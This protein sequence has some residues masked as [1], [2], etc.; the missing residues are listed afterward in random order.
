[1]N[2][3]N[4]IPIE[5]ISGDSMQLYKG[6][7]IGTGKITPSE[8]KG[9]PHYMLDIKEA[10]ESFSVAEF[11]KMV[12]YYISHIHSKQKI[13][14]IVGGTGLYIQ[15][16]LYDYQFQDRKRDEGLTKKLEDR[17]Q[18]EGNKALYEELLSIDRNY[19]L[20]I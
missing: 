6:M 14:V 12:Q 9:I 17:I 3:A 8:K 15:A 5:I 13:P 11:Q 7:D 20:T 4:D 18:K 1:I 19:A 16:V 2:L 10:D